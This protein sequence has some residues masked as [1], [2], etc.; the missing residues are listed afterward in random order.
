M[1]WMK[2]ALQKAKEERNAAEPPAEA[3]EARDTPAEEG[4][5]VDFQTRVSHVSRDE[6]RRN[7]MVA[8]DEKHPA[9][10]QF[11]LLR[12]RIFHRTRQKGWNAIQVTG[13]NTGD[14]K[15]LVAANLAISMAQDA[16][17]TALLV[18]LDFR[19]PTLHEL[20]GLGC[21]VAGLKSYFFED[22]PLERLLVN[23]GI[24][25]LTLLPA[26]C[27]T[28]QATELMGSPRMEALVKEL[29]SRYRNRYIIFDTPPVNECS[30]LLVFSEYVDA[31]VLV[32]RAD[33][34][35]RRAS[36]PP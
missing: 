36:G 32:A 13:F 35:T 19:N 12:T 27:P 16:R 21:D 15:S 5:S 28:A 20:F 10:N 3:V 24:E 9:S 22:I 34:T 2:K 1:S 31:M 26:G 33:H 30:D 18:D 29:K 25:R 4:A 8:L 11:K 14:G 7:C 17:Q 6:L 23:P